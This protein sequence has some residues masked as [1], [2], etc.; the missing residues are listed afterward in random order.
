MRILEG[1]V[2]WAEWV[3]WVEWE[4]WV[5]WVEWVAM[6]VSAALVRLKHLLNV[7]GPF[8]TCTDSCL[9]FSKLGGG[10]GGMP[11]LGDMAND[12]GGGDDVSPFSSTCEF[13]TTAS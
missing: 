10:A 11:D 13:H 12:M 4:V 6:V 8:G 5:E 1:W 7:T 2:I 3:V 9:D